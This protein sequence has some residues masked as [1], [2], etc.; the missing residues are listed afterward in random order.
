LV[1]FA[2]GKDGARIAFEVEGAGP[3]VILLH[4]GAGTRHDWREFGYVCGLAR[5]F[6]VV[7][8]NLRGHGESDRP[9]D[10][11]GLTPWARVNNLLGNDTSAALSAL[12]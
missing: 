5:D 1:E 6:T 12:R 4:R 10:P 9:I 7:A 2:Q 3:V 11:A 8:L